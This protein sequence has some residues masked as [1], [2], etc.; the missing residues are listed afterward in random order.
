MSDKPEENQWNKLL[1]G[2]SKVAKN[3][4]AH[5]LVLGDYN[6]GKRSIINQL[7]QLTGERTLIE[8]R[9]DQ[10]VLSFMKDKRVSSAIDYKYY[11]VKNPDDENMELG[12]VNIWIF[13]E[14]ADKDLLSIILNKDVMKNLMVMIIQDFEQYWDI[15][16]NL[17]K[18]NEI[19]SQYI[20]P[21]MKKLQLKEVDEAKERFGT[22]IK[23]YIEPKITDSGKTQTKRSE[24]DPENWGSYQLPK[25]L[26]ETNYGF[27]VYLVLNKCESVFEM[28]K[29]TDVLEMIEYKVRQWALD[30]A[31]SIFYAS[32]KMNTNMNTLYSYINYY[33]FDIPHHVKVNISKDAL[34]VPSG[35]DNPTVL[36]ETFTTVKGKIFEE[37]IVKPIDAKAKGE[38]KESVFKIT[39]HQS[40]LQDLKMHLGNFEPGKLSEADGQK[41]KK[42]SSHLD[43]IR[44]GDVQGRTGTV[45]APVPANQTQKILM[46]LKEKKTQRTNE[47]DKK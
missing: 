27:P 41:D 2:Y 32:T 14:N 3:K 11:T 36:E 34:F 19:I 42:P 1:S 29:L 8:S 20:Y 46:M 24:I 28:R 6:S 35:F 10:S 17:H 37:V 31:A 4:D 33:F 23:N 47:E 5:L 44:K 26:L 25:G 18:Y 16:D 13:D 12:K 21:H 30:T 38:K 45:Q 15:S 40:Y 22:F 9:S 39:D 43:K 7:E